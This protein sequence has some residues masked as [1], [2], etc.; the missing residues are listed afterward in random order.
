[1]TFNPMNPIKSESII[2]Q[3]TRQVLGPEYSEI[4]C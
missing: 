3:L 2:R 1:M 4:D